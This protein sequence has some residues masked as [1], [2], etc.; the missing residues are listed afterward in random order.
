M[1]EEGSGRRER[2][3]A[4]RLLHDLDVSVW[5]QRFRDAHLRPPAAGCR[6]RAR[7]RP[8][9]PRPP[10]RSRGRR[11]PPRPRRARASPPPPARPGSAPSSA[12]PPPR[13]RLVASARRA[14]KPASA[15]PWGPAPKAQE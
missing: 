11:S 8:T 4:G 15:A 3:G 1:R 13:G 5:L 10:P 6:P 12:P 2:A 7:G 9:R 14:R